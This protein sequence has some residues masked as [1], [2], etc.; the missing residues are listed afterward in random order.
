GSPLP[1]LA[2]AEALHGGHGARERD[3]RRRHGRLTQSGRHLL[4]PL[5]L[6]QLGFA[7]DAR[8]FALAFFFGQPR[9]LLATD[10]LLFGLVIP[11]QPTRAGVER[12]EAVEEERPEVARRFPGLVGVVADL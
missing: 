9:F 1:V 3:R 11:E 12:V 6:E 7:V 10:A 5:L 2:V 4:L 8:L